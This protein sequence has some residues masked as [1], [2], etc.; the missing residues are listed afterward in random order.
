MHET[1]STNKVLILQRG[2]VDVVKNEVQLARISEPG[3]VFGEMSFILGRPHTAAVLASAPSSF[4]VVDDVKSLLLADPEIAHFLMVVL[5]KRLDDVNGLLIEARA[6][7]LESR[8]HPGVL[9][10]MFAKIGRALRISART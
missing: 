3:A 7:Y 8:K 2:V 9:E 6:L 1:S 4:F 5:A 10:D